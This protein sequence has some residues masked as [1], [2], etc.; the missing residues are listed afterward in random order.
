VI[1]TF[2]A[3]LLLGLLLLPGVAFAQGVGIFVRAS[4][5]T[6]NAPV[7]GG[8]QCFDS[9][10]NQLRAWNGVSWV[11]VGAQP[12]IAGGGTTATFTLDPNGRMTLPSSLIVGGGMT[13]GSTTD[14]G[15]GTINVASATF[16]NN[17]AAIVASGSGANL[18]NIRG[19]SASS[20]LSN[21]LRGT[22]TFAASATCSVNFANNEPNA[23]YFVMTGCA[24]NV[25]S[26]TASGF[27][28][29]ATGTNSNSCDFLVVR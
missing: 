27:T 23:H 20:S 9:T 8:T 4:C 3:S 7:V 21:N 13:I 19:L 25:G 24:V 17:L 18:A 14:Q 6:L 1:S 29:T 22:C 26:K 11:A 2:F 16:A 28:M 12:S 15:T 5:S 10:F